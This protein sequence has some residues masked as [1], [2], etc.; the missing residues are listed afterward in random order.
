M[1]TSKRIIFI[2]LLL[3]L[4]LATIYMLTLLLPELQASRVN[5]QI[6]PPAAVIEVTPVPRDNSIISQAQATA[7]ASQPVTEIQLVA[8]SEGLAQPVA[9][10]HAYDDRLFVAE[11]AGVI[12][13]I[14]NGT[15]LSEPFL[16]IQH[17][18][19]NDPENLWDERGLL[20]L[21]FHPNF[22]ENGLFFINY[23]SERD[24][25]TILSRYR[26]DDTNPNQA[27]LLSETVMLNIGQPYADHN[28]GHL[29]FD[30]D[31]FLYMAVGDG[32]DW[33][34]RRENGQNPSTLLGNILRL[35]VDA[36]DTYAVPST[37][38]FVGDTSKRG[39]IW[40]YGLR[41][42]WRFSFDRLTRDLYIAD[43]GQAVWE[44]VSFLPGGGQGGENLGWNITEGP[45]CYEADTCD[46]SK[47]IEPIVTYNH[48][49]GACA[50]VGGYVYRGQQF[51]SLVGNYFFADF[52]QG[53][54]WS[55]INHNGEWLQNEV[56]RDDIWISSFGEDVDGELYVLDHRNGFVYQVQ[57]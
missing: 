38:P 43:V 57:P 37:N 32:G 19:R 18:V 30:Q 41:N 8:I 54:V 4:S 42:P 27:D 46:K 36:N 10:A 23:T 25:S 50:V 16:D 1:K 35:H 11:Q 5:S 34:D 2:F 15:L 56:Y 28:A 12:R 33:G 31:G 22:Q 48:S 39:E 55:L 51:P 49:T 26:V 6:V 47:F 17:K 52:C 9:L 44:E 21:V 3:I 14:E 53:I 20:G 13:I 7:V 29:Q 40:V 24:G 45:V